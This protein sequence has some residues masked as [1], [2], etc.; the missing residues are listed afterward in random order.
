MPQCMA[1]RLSPFKLASQ[2]SAIRRILPFSHGELFSMNRIFFDREIDNLISP[3]LVLEIKPASSYFA[4]C[5]PP[6]HILIRMWHK[7]IQFLKRFFLL[8]SGLFV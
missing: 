1:V 8:M 2:N 4:S 7:L 5:T 6:S 3:E